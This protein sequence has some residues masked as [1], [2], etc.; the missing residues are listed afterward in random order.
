MVSRYLFLWILLDKPCGA[1][2]TCS[3]TFS[4]AG[5]FGEC[6]SW[7]QTDAE[8]YVCYIVWVEE[9]APYS[10][11]KDKMSQTISATLLEVMRLHGKG[12]VFG[13]DKSFVPAV[14]S[15]SV[16]KPQWN[17]YGFKCHFSG[18]LNFWDFGALKGGGNKI[19]NASCCFV[20]RFKAGLE[21]QKDFW[22]CGSR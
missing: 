4:H 10:S 12:S 15:S 17:L 16:G 18:P 6:E 9:I 19:E 7:D 8:M 14:T 20:G 1:Q 3:S 13:K 21:L 2:V 11:C 5:V 22:K